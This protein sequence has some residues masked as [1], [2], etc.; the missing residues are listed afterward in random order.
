MSSKK[1]KYHIVMVIKTSFYDASLM[2]TWIVSERE[3]QQMYQ[4]LP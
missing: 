2:K 4:N 1:R 3:R